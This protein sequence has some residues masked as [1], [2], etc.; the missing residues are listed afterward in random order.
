MPTHQVPGGVAAQHFGGRVTLLVCFLTWSL[1]S[2]ATPTEARHANA[3][4]LARV[5]VGISQGFLIPAV[6]TVLSQVRDTCCCARL[7]SQPLP[8][9]IPPQER[10]R[11]VSLT[12]SGMYLGSATAM[13]VMPSVAAALGAGALFKVR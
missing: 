9:W 5:V 1:A 6:H 10:A 11:S 3:L 7:V 12:T 8:Q 13:W 4:A 2:L